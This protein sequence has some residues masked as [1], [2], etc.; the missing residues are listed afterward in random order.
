[1]RTI[2]VKKDQSLSDIA[3]QEYGHVEGVFFLVED[4][5]ILIGITDNIYEGDELL[6][7]E[8]QINSPMQTFLADYVIAIAKGARGC[9]IGYWGI[10]VDFE[11][12]PSPD[13]NHDFNNDFLNY[14]TNC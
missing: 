13:F 7:R 11:M 14:G 2:R 3:L 5:V 8:D 10:E 12:Q 9:G 4:N 1:M 6:I